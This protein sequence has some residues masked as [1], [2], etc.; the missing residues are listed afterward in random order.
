MLIAVVGLRIA[1]SMPADLRASWI[2]PMVDPPGLVLRSGLWRAL[3]LT[4]VVPVVLG[5]A[6]FHAWLW[7]ARLA[8][9]HAGVM[10][11][12]GTLLV[13]MALWHVDDM[14]NRRPWRPEHAN[15]RF[16]WPAYLVGFTTVTVRLPQLERAYQD[17]PA[18]ASAVIAGACML[19]AL[20]VRIAHRQPY[21]P[22]PFDIE[23]FV[24]SPHILNLE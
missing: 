20:A 5:F 12:A 24:E 3:F 13:E 14:S 18:T 4:S 23:T 10:L 22:P 21:P 8:L 2:V 9:A 6:A 16:W 17:T 7:G 11:G 1:I 19:V 15:L